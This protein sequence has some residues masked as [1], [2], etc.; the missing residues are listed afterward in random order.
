MVIFMIK[1]TYKKTN[2]LG[3]KLGSTIKTMTNMGA[4]PECHI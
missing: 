2:K 3:F 1:K 4:T